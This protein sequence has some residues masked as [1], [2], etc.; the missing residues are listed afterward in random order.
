MARRVRTSQSRG[1]PDQPPWRNPEAPGHL[2]ST[3]SSELADFPRNPQV[4][5]NAL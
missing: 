5:R 4:V 3:D 1:D 2:T